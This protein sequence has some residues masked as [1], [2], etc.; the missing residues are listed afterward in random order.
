MQAKR[1][2]T[3]Q[4]WNAG[5]PTALNRSHPI[6]KMFKER[7]SGLEIREMSCFN[8]TIRSLYKRNQ[9]YSSITIR[10]KPPKL[11]QIKKKYEPKFTKIS[12]RLYS[13]ITY[14]RRL[15]ISQIKY[16]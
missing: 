3:I 12:K 11:S 1:P 7:A 14:G 8:N 6:L 16:K 13:L 2:K 10:T 5:L 4:I 9:P 15:H